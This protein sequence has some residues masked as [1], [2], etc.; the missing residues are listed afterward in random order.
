MRTYPSSKPLKPGRFVLILLAW[1]M[2][3]MSSAHANRKWEQSQSA[4]FTVITDSPNSGDA[5]IALLGD[6]HALSEL[7]LTAPN[8]R[9]VVFFLTS[10]SSQVANAWPKG[11]AIE[12]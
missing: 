5:I 12:G 7:G 6:V 3:S 4:N 2:A 10:D 9:P 8:V 1:L 11:V